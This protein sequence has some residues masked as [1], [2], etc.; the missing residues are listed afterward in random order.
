MDAAAPTIT[1]A[2][3]NGTNTILTIIGTN[4]AGPH[5]QAPV[6]QLD[7]MTLTVASTTPTMLTATLPAN[8]ASG[9]Y[10]LFVI[11]GGVLG[12]AALD[13]TLGTAGP[14]GPIGAAGATGATGAAGAT[15]ATGQQGVPGAMGATEP[16]ADRADWR[17]RLSRSRWTNRSSW[18]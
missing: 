7:S 1:S 6:V 12:T 13:M 2:M 14:A 9:S 16:R 17:A 4:L 5:N 3:A 10:H 18:R 15:G 8:L 11:K